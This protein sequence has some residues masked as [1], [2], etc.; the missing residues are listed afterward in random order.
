MSENAITTI[1]KKYA[2]AIGLKSWREGIESKTKNIDYVFRAA[3]LWNLSFT[4]M[5]RRLNS[6]K[7]GGITLSEDNPTCTRCREIAR[8]EVL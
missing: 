5:K 1:T 4:S 8:T 7:D 2:M 3:G 6:L